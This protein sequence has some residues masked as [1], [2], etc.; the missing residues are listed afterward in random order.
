MIIID[1]Y[2]E[3]KILYEYKMKNNKIEESCIHHLCLPL[4]F[5]SLFVL[6]FQKIPIII[7]KILSFSGQENRTVV[8]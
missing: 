3:Q 2:F 6:I 5:I 8:A 7:T 1:D 4:I